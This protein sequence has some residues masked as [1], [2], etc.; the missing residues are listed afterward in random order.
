MNILTKLLLIGAIIYPFN[1]QAQAAMTFTDVFSAGESGYNCFRI[2]AIVKAP[3]GALLAFAEGRISGCGDFG[4]VDIVLKT[5]KNGGK[6]WGNLAVVAE[7]G[8]LQAGNPTPV[9]DRL[10]P[11][12]PQGRLLL[13][14]NTGN[15]SEH[16]VRLG[17]GRREVWF[18]ASEDEGMTWSRPTNISAMTHRPLPDS[19]DWRSYANAPG[20]GIQLPSGRIFIPA[21][22]SSGPP[23]DGFLDYQAHAFYTDDHCKTFRLSPSIAY[24]GSNE[25]TAARLLSG[26]LLMSI[27]DQSGKAGHRLLAL[28]QTGGESWDSVWVAM[29]LPDPVCQGSLLDFKLKDGSEVLLHSNPDSQS[30]RCC[31]AVKISRDSGK[32]WSLLQLVY[33]G[34]AAYSDLVQV[35]SEQI[36]CLFEAD[37]YKLI[38]FGWFCP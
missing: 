2:P 37:G 28:S 10:D 12:F 5:S 35:D 3:S 19:A 30:E 15:N 32:N 24:Q 14:Y 18:I 22:H 26:G 4:D 27:R 36:G 6:S 17:N 11:A 34:A 16:Q 8:N 9:F 31:L 38:K 23:K 7:N 21:N 29:D 13:F 25:S 1:V 20:H 33:P